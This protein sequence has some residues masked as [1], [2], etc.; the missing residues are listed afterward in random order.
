[1]RPIETPSSLRSS[2]SVV[3]N[4][5][6]TLNMFQ[7][8]L[9]DSRNLS[10]GISSLLDSQRNGY[11]SV[12]AYLWAFPEPE[13][14]LRLREMYD[15]H[16]KGLR[17]LNAVEYSYL[18][19]ILYRSGFAKDVLVTTRDA[20]KDFSKAGAD[21]RSGLLRVIG[22]IGNPNDI[23]LVVRVMLSME[24]QDPLKQDAIF[25]VATIGRHCRFNGTLRYRGNSFDAASYLASLWCTENSL[26]VPPYGVQPYEETEEVFKL[27]EDT[28]SHCVRLLAAVALLNCP[29]ESACALKRYCDGMESIAG[30]SDLSVSEKKHLAHHASILKFRKV[31]V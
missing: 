1:M 26:T 17:K 5:V 20:L 6:M 30:R 23:D 28:T 3:Q 19:S 29:I 25:A 13:F 24:A 21:Q 2:L 18:V 22:L 31:D 8:E 4:L 16:V 11:V 9:E 7:H 14:D 15:N 10:N 12:L 27:L